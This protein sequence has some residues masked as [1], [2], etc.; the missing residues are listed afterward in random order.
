MDNEVTEFLSLTKPIKLSACIV[1]RI[2]LF[3]VKTGQRCFNKHN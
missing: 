1:M 3:G 2:E